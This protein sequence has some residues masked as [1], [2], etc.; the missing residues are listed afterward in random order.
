MRIIDV[1]GYASGQQ[2]NKEKSSVMFGSK[3][4]TSTKQDLKR[5]TGINK[6]GGLG[7]YLGMPKKL[8][9]SKKQVFAYV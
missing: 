9:G 2:L 8:W 6:E 4:I 1:Y 3:V 5:L 7:M